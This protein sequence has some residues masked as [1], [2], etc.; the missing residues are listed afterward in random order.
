MYTE[1]PKACPGLELKSNDCFILMRKFIHSDLK[2]SC[3][4]KQSVELRSECGENL[5]HVLTSIETHSA[6]NWTAVDSS[7]E[8]NTCIPGAFRSF[9][10]YRVEY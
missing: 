6:L 3:Q 4:V 9:G 5:K 2:V 8:L 10:V 1:K 7:A